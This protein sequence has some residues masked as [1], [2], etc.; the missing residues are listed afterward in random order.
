M[1][2]PFLLTA[3]K[4]PYP[5]LCDY[6]WLLEVPLLVGMCENR[7][8]PWSFHR[9]VTRVTG[10]EIEWGW[11]QREEQAAQTT[12]PNTIKILGYIV[13][14]PPPAYHAPPAA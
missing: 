11:A 10:T 14:L 4:S 7:L 12:D 8:K 13:D 3:I 1:C 9:S 6:F 5:F 2:S